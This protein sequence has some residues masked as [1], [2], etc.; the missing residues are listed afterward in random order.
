MA[1]ILRKDWLS[2][3]LEYT[4]GQESPRNFHFWT[5]LSILGGA[6]RR[7]VVLDRVYYK[8]FPNLYVIL[9]AASAACKKKCSNRNR[10]E[11]IT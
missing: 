7:N 3:Y 1:R 8:L 6:L 4:S 9:V 2:S 10:D 11:D 5:G